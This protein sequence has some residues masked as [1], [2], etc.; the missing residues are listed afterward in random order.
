VLCSFPQVVAGNEYNISRLSSLHGGI[1]E[2]ARHILHNIVR[3][4]HLH[5]EKDLVL[6]LQSHHELLHQSA[7]A[8]H[9]HVPNHLIFIS[10]QFKIL[11][12]FYLAHNMIIYTD[13]N[14]CAIH[15]KT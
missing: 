4:L 13:Y 2:W 5:H 8:L 1:E 14:C 6:L 12:P 10:C 15:S 11:R 3:L 7:P 9:R